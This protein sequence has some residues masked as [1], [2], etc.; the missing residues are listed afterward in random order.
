MKDSTLWARKCEVTGEG[1]SAGYV[2]YE[3]V[4]I[5]NEDD[6]IDYMR[7]ED[8]DLWEDVS[9]EYLLQEGYHAGDYYYTEW[10]DL[11]DMQY[12]EVDRKL[13]EIELYT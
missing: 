10:T 12:I 7:K 2:V 6:L 4:T 13:Y 9:D 3:D 1:M 11:D 8:P 5:K